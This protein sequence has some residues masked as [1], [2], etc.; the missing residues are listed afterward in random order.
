MQDELETRRRRARWRAQHRGTKELD[1]LLGGFAEARLAT[2]NDAELK[3]FEAVLS[4]DE[5]RLQRWLLAPQM[6]EDIASDVQP[7]VVAVRAFH[8]LNIDRGKDAH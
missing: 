8:G 7:M 5:P 2:M 3:A 1:L 6:A 4:L